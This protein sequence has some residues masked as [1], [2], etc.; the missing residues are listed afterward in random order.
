MFAMKQT[1]GISLT[2]VM[3]ASG[4]WTGI[5]ARHDPDSTQALEAF[6]P[7][8][9][10]DA[11]SLRV[12]LDVSASPACF[13]S[14]SAV[15]ALR[16]VSAETAPGDGL[17]VRDRQFATGIETRAQFDA[18][19][20]QGAAWFCG[21]FLAHPPAVTGMRDSNR[22]VLLRLLSLIAQDADS[23]EIEQVFKRE[24][25]LSYNLFRLVNSVSMGLSTKVS[26]FNQAIMVL[27]RRQMQRWIQLMLYTSNQTQNESADTLMQLAA[28]RAKLMESL[29]KA[30]G[31][32]AGAQER[33]F[34][35]GIFSLLDSL[36]GMSMADIVKAIPLPDDVQ[37]ALLGQEGPQSALLAWVDSLQQGRDEPVP[38]ACAALDAAT[39]AACQLAAL[40]WAVG[41]GQEMGAA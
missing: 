33:A 25:G 36:L 4:A 26:T 30:I 31:W 6:C 16:V 19:K 9:A 35:A 10:E 38:S 3:D 37:A 23:A 18:A 13:E 21:A 15:K 39:L 28:M 29:A 22:A 34:M 40:R 32:D 11:G 7:A 14:L 5:W 17:A 1:V 24:P 8:L 20:A 12:F 2:P 27:G 41:I